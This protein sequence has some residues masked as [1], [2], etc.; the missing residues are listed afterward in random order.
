M[1]LGKQREAVDGTHVQPTARLEDAG[2]FRDDGFGIEAV[3]QRTERD[4]ASK[5]TSGEREVL[6]IATHQRRADARALQATTR[7]DEP[8]E[9]DVD[10]DHALPAPLTREYEVGGAAAYVDPPASWRLIGRNHREPL[11]GARLR[12]QD[13]PR[14]AFGL[15]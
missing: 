9:C 10:A 6:A 15:L 14:E 3:L 5:G 12:G 11:G 2:S 13:E 1:R 4:D 8:A 7:D